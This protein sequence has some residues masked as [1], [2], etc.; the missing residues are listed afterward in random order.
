MAPCAVPWQPSVRHHHQFMGP[1]AVPWQLSVRDHHQLM[2][3]P[4]DDSPPRTVEEIAEVRRRP[5]NAQEKE[6]LAVWR[7]DQEAA[8]LAAHP[9]PTGPRTDQAIVA[10]WGL[11]S[12]CTKED[13]AADLAEFDYEPQQIVCCGPGAFA[14]ALNA[15]WQAKGDGGRAPESARCCQRA[16]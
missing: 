1:W 15:Q 4:G 14:L 3:S 16:H 11:N 6:A 12:A 13:L 7:A 2:A 9:V 5:S 10:I 8:R